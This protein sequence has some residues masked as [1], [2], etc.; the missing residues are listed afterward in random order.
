MDMDKK[1]ILELNV[2]DK[3]VLVYDNAVLDKEERVT[4][5]NRIY[6]RGYKEHWRDLTGQY[7]I[8]TKSGDTFGEDGN[9]VKGAGLRIEP[10]S[11][12]IKDDQRRASIIFSITQSVVDGWTGFTTDEL[13]ALYV[14]LYGRAWEDAE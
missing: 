3:V 8:E 5:V 1:W 14:K 2:G 13:K 4:E 10:M 6:P 12:R 7:L 11:K 9:D